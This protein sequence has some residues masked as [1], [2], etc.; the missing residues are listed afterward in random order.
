MLVILLDLTRAGGG[1][2]LAT[3]V[4]DGSSSPPSVELIDVRGSCS[5]RPEGD[6]M[7]TIGAESDRGLVKPK[8][9]LVGVVR[10]DT[11]VNARA[12]GVRSGVPGAGARGVDAK[13]P[14][15]VLD[16][17]GVAQTSVDEA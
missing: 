1:R 9:C 15:V 8:E 16:D 7:T 17:V 10:E 2:G 6:E 14:L 5:S 12:T 11:L 3:G 4:C 13:E